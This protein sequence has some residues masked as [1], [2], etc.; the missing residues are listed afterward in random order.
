[1]T[2][3]TITVNIGELAYWFSQD[4]KFIIHCPEET[5]LQKLTSNDYS[6]CMSHSVGGVMN[7]ASIS[8]PATGKA[9]QVASVG[10]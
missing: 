1:M 3:H 2:T 6:L 8:M 7:V 9:N 10:R 5:I 4:D